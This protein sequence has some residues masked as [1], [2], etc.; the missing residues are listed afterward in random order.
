MQNIQV[1]T[2]KLVGESLKI[3]NFEPVDALK[4]L[5]AKIVKTEYLDDGSVVIYAITNLINDKVERT[6]TKDAKDVII[7]FA[8]TSE[9]NNMMHLVTRKTLKD[10]NISFR[11]LR[12][13]FREKGINYHNI[14]PIFA[15]A[16]PS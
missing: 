5:N 9:L 8:G 13:W 15:M 1:D 6:M 3:F 11:D 14:E 2:S 10:G 12:Y 7:P 16:E 4:K